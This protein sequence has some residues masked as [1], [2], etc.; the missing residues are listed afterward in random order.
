MVDDPNVTPIGARLGSQRLYAPPDAPDDY[1]PGRRASRPAPAPPPSPP[2][3]AAHGATMLGSTVLEL[4]GITTLTVG[5]YLIAP[6]VGLIVAGLCL[7]LL[8]V[9]LGMAR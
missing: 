9:A 2:A 1:Q 7:I 6:F 8:G 4:A 5:C 3:V